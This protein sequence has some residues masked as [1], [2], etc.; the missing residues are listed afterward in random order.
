MDTISFADFEKVEMRVG[1]IRE[2]LDNERA[3]KPA[4]K[5]RVDF[6]GEIG[7]KWSSAQLTH[8]AK[9]ALIGRQVIAVINF[10]P[11]NIAG[12][13]SEILILGVP[14]AEGRA[15]LLS[16]ERAVEPGGRVY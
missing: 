3:R 2:V 16:P 10:A 6:G 7:E 8:Y 13:T 5:V 9:D 4:Y 14:D 1:V 15:I 11:K 12:F